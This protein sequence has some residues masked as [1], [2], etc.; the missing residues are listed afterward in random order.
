M[1]SSKKCRK[2][3]ENEA[4]LKV[5]NNKRASKCEHRCGSGIK[6]GFTSCISRHFVRCMSEEPSHPH[7][8]GMRRRLFF[9]GVLT[10]GRRDLPLSGDSG[11]GKGPIW[12]I[13][14][15]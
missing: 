12:V 5:Y 8:P 14:V 7:F 6:L 15:R 9:G 11:G 10:R 4:G 2:E 1:G 13:Q 3:V